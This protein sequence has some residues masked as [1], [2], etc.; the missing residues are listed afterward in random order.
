MTHTEREQLNHRIAELIAQ[1]TE[2]QYEDFLKRL[3]DDI[4]KGVF[5]MKDKNGDLSTEA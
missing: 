2:Q 4:D 3:T 5:V 1:L